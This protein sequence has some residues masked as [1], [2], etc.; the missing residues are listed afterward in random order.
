MLA[1]P[2][3]SAKQK[4][5]FC[6]FACYGFFSPLQCVCSLSVSIP[7]G[8]H[9]VVPTHHCFFWVHFIPTGHFPQK[10]LSKNLRIGFFP[11]PTARPCL[12]THDH[13]FLYWL[14]IGWWCLGLA[15]ASPS[16]P[17]AHAFAV[18]WRLVC[19]FYRALLAFYCVGCFPI[20]HSL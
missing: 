13:H 20:C 12:L 16:S 11:L 6:L 2:L 19:T 3:P 5:L 9:L 1:V 7:H 8:I 14:G 17:V 4:R 15:R 10:C 18:F